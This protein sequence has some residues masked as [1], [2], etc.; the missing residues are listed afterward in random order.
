MPVDYYVGRSVEELTV[1]LRAAQERKAR[2][3]VVEVSAAGVRTVRDFAK[4][5]QVEREIFDLRYALHVRAAGTDDAAKWPDPAL[6]RIS[7]TRTRYSGC[8]WSST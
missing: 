7:R 5:T 4:N 6:E 3:N 1:L 8:G 2:G